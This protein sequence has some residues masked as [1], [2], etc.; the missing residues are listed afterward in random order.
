[1]YESAGAE[2]TVIIGDLPDDA[3]VFDANILEQPH[4]ELDV[5]DGKV[6]VFFTPWQVKTLLIQI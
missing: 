3:K 4:K 6:Q 2:G 1:L 5:T